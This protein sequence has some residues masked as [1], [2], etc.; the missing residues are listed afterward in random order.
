MATPNVGYGLERFTLKKN[1]KNCLKEL[2]C[3]EIKMFI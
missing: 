3:R 1:N 2:F